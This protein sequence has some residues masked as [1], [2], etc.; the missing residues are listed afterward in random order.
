MRAGGGGGV[1]GGVRRRH[2][3]AETVTV[4]YAAYRLV[5]DP[6]CR[7]V[8]A[9]YSQILANKFSRKIKHLVGKLI[10]LSKD[11][12]AVEEWE[13]ESG[14]GL[15][16]V[17]I[18]GGITGQG[19]DLL[20]IDD[21][22]KSRQEADSVAFRERLYNW[23]TDDLYTRIEPG[24]QIVLIMTR[25]HEDDLAGR[26]AA[27]EGEEDGDQWVSLNLPAICEDA[28]GDPLGRQVG[29]ALCP[30]RYDEAALRRIRKVSERT[31]LALYQGRP[32]AQEGNLFKRHWWKF[33]YPRDMA[34]APPPPVKVR[35]ETDEIVEC[36]QAPLPRSFD[37]TIQSWD[38]TFKGEQDSDYVVGQ[39]WGRKAAEKFL[40]DQYRDQ[41][42][43]PATIKAVM[44]TSEKWPGATTKLIEDKANG[45]AI[46]QTLRKRIS[47]IIPV[48]PAG[49]KEARANAVSATI[50]AGDVYL[51][52]PAL[53][54]WV[55]AFLEETS[56]F[57]SGTHDDQVDA[58]S[59]ALIV[60]LSHESTWV[61]EKPREMTED[62]QW[63]KTLRELGVTPGG[64]RRP[65]TGW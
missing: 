4:R 34:D 12:S 49:G 3:K 18:G 62:E 36:A 9:S 6:N 44:A 64:R 43:F 26:L 39:V 7:V 38:A 59:Q 8:I 5:A 42:D 65:S 19:F 52:H 51:P 57:P 35:L 23:Y 56:S 30:D 40:L 14:G 58:M 13:T 22:V 24:G 10:P 25:W 63:D 2:W 37:E 16:A 41:A 47:G 32:T 21:P 50:E 29:Q 27:A 20:I 28:E 15:R 55:K 46:I 17:G 31:F 33:W 48:E 60:L 54:P 1:V 53:C 45:S 61:P 11:R